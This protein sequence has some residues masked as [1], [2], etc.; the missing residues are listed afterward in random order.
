ME[1]SEKLRQ[2]LIGMDVLLAAD[3]DARTQEWFEGKVPSDDP[4]G[5]DRAKATKDLVERGLLEKDDDYPGPR[6]P[7]PY[8][9]TT[10]GANFL[11]GVRRQIGRGK[12]IH[13]ERIND[14]EFPSL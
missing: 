9:L 14:I 11:D 4:D 13:W 1:E 12:G 6:H 10:R 7:H 2:K 3:R 5:N 8:R